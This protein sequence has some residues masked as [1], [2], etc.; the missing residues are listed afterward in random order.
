[1]HNRKKRRYLV[2]L[3]LLAVLPIYPVYAAGSTPPRLID[4]ADL[5]SGGEENGAAKER[6]LRHLQSHRRLQGES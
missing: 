1:M 5:L 2:L 4:E 3:L 6:F